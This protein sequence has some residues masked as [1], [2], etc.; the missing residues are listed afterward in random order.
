MA[1]LISYRRYAAS[2]GA[3]RGYYMAV[4][5]LVNFFLLALLLLLSVYF[6]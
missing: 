1:S 4:F 3:R 5:S 6:F 2:A